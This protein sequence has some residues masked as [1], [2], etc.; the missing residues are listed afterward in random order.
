MLHIVHGGIENGDKAWLEK[1]A[2]QGLDA[3]SWI[4]PK[5]AQIGDEVVI[6]V[7]GHGFYAT[8]R[9]TMK[10][11]PYTRWPNRYTAGIGAIRLIDPPISIGTIQIEIP[12]LK[13]ANYPRSITTPS[14]RIEIRIAALIKQRRKAGLPRL[15]EKS[16][17]VARLEELRRVAVLS[18]KAK[19]PGK[20]S[21]ALTRSRSTAIK[22]Y[23]LARAAG[24]CEGCRQSAPFVRSGGSHYLEPHHTTRL[25][26]DGPDHP[27]KVIA[28]CPNCH[29]KA[30]YADDR[31]AFNQRLIKILRRLEMNNR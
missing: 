13:W 6:Y 5:R 8:A 12:Q 10:P 16:L 9:I 29:R 27:A 2:K 11:R 31:K 30:H 3:R 14:P 19:V 15:D 21:Q 22:R 23:V 18:S 24:V 20:N 28:L 26:D 1:A 25:S 17:A 4:V 7:T